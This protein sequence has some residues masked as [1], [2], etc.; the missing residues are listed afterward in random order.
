MTREIEITEL[1]ETEMVETDGG[2]ITSP[3]LVPPPPPP[4]A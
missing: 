3:G 2:R 1:T 4:M